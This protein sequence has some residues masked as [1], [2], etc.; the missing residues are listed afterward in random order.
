MDYINVNAYAKIN[1]GLD[2][3]RKRPDGYHDV[4]M[5][6]QTIDMYDKININKNNKSTINIKTNLF[7]LP[8]DS[9]NIV[10][11]AA[12]LFFNELDISGGI[13]INIKKNI[14]VSAG[15]AGGSADA[16]ATLLGL[17]HLYKCNLSASDLMELGVKIG[18]DVPYCILKG[19]A[20][21]EGIGEKLT[22][23]KPFPDCY[24]VLVK[25]PI[26]VS[27]KYV[28]GNL[29]L[30]DK[31]NH[32]NIKMIIEAINNNDLCAISNHMDNILENVTIKR[33]PVIQQIKEKL[34]KQNA[35]ASIMSGSGPSVY[36]VFDNYDLA[37]NSY[38]TLKSSLKHMD[39]FLS[40]PYWP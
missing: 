19:T 34:L 27:T 13:N 1:I 17:N 14:P 6:M 28:Y 23:L 5:I 2:V 8:N 11:K 24:I 32:P 25:P 15:L 29:V 7:F 37:L 30:N 33:Y 3:L 36:G 4:S 22:P 31:T 38:N 12:E 21:S 10:Y 35:I 16:A 9:R 20:L 26:S 18:A 39:V 40:K